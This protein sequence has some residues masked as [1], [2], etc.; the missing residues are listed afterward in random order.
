[1]HKHQ[2][3]SRNPVMSF[4][5]KRLGLQMKKQ[6]I[7]WQVVKQTFSRQVNEQKCNHNKHDSMWKHKDYASCGA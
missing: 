7:F 3:I 4:C 6:I 5:L 2:Q 1:M